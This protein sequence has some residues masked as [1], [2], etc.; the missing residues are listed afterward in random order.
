MDRKTEDKEVIP[1]YAGYVKKQ[2]QIVKLHQANAC[3]K[4]YVQTNS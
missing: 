2:Q 4:L 3:I 1:A